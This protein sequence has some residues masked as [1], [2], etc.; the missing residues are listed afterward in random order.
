MPG[1]AAVPPAVHVH[2]PSY[3]FPVPDS[4]TRVAELVVGAA[5]RLSARLRKPG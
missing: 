5:G 2:G 1:L 3:R 4:E